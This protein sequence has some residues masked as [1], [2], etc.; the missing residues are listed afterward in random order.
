MCYGR[1][2]GAAML[3]KLGE[4]SEFAEVN[5]DNV[6]SLETA[7]NGAWILLIILNF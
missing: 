3:A 7:L 1:E 4:N 5:I 2:K 6:K